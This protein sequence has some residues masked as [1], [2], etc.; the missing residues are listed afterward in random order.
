MTYIGADGSQ[1]KE[2]LEQQRKKAAEEAKAKEAESLE[3]SSGS[4]KPETAPESTNESRTQAAA[5]REQNTSGSGQNQ[6]TLL[7]QTVRGYTPEAEPQTQATALLTHLKKQTSE[8][9]T[10]D[11]YSDYNEGSSSESTQRANPALQ[12]VQTQQN[13]RRESTQAQQAVRQLSN[14]QKQKIIDLSEA[15]IRLGKS[16]E[17]TQ[18]LKDLFLQPQNAQEIL[19]GLEETKNQADIDQATKAIDQ[20]LIQAKQVSEGSDGSAKVATEK[21]ETSERL[22]REIREIQEAEN[23]LSQDFN[24]RGKTKDQRDTYFNSQNAARATLAKYEH[25]RSDTKTLEE[26]KQGNLDQSEEA[27][28]EWTEKSVR[29]NQA[30]KDSTRTFK[31]AEKLFDAGDY[32]GATKVATGESYTKDEVVSLERTDTPL[33]TEL[34]GEA[35]T[36]KD[37]IEFHDE[38][39]RKALQAQETLTTLIAEQKALETKAADSKQTE[40]TRLASLQAAR[41]LEA[42]IQEQTRTTHGLQ[43]LQAHITKLRSEGNFSDIE[44]LASGKTEFK[45]EQRYNDTE[46]TKKAV[47][48]KIEL[49]TKQATEKEYRQHQKES[50]ENERAIAQ[51]KAKLALMQ[52]TLAAKEKEVQ[53]L[54]RRSKITEQ[55]EVDK[56]K[57]EIKKLEAK[58]SGQQNRSLQLAQKTILANQT[59]EAANRLE[60]KGDFAAAEKILNGEQLETTDSLSMAMELPGVSVEEAKKLSPEEVRSKEYQEILATSI[61]DLEEQSSSYNQQ[62]ESTQRLLGNENLTAEQRQEILAQQKTIQDNLAKVQELTENTLKTQTSVNELYSQGKFQEIIA[63]Q[64]QGLSEEQRAEMEYRYSLSPEE[65]TALNYREVLTSS[66]AKFQEQNTQLQQQL[67]LSLKLL[68]NNNLSSEQRQELLNRQAFLEQ[69]LSESQRVTN[70][71]MQ[72]QNQITDLYNQ[73]KYQEII[74]IQS[75]KSKV[76]I[77]VSNNP[78]LI[79]ESKKTNNQELRLTT[80][81]ASFEYQ[82]LLGLATKAD[83]DMKRLSSILERNGR[84]SQAEADEYGDLSIFGRHLRNSLIKDASNELEQAGVV[85]NA[86]TALSTKRAEAEKLFREGDIEGARKVLKEGLMDS[87]G[88]KNE[89][90]AAMNEHYNSTRGEAEKAIN[91]TYQSLRNTGVAAVATVATV[92]SMG[93]LSTLTGPIILKGFVVG[94]AVGTAFG[95]T[96]TYIDSTIDPTKTQGQ[97]LSDVVNGLGGDAYNSAKASISTIISIGVLQG[98]APASASTANNVSNQLFSRLSQSSQQALAYTSSGMAGSVPGLV[99]ETATKIAEREKLTSQLREQGKS[100]A[101]IEQALKENRLDSLTMLQDASVSLAAAGASSFVGGKS[102]GLQNQNTSLTDALKIK[103]FSCEVI[104]MPVS[105]SFSYLKLA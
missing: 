65:R 88:E 48:R 22:A 28:Q 8:D 33:E 54:N 2:Q 7:T 38:V 46:Q 15:L 61:K 72:T 79:Q 55:T 47:E 44:D 86:K 57:A 78:D 34:T 3:A 53:K 104:E 70:E 64:N 93:S 45:T 11:V 39:T 27:E 85:L 43:E 21:Q 49:S 59:L 40:E 31:E 20:A 32:E 60:A 73:G 102:A 96:V 18:A 67:E 66:A 97:A 50:Q 10:N 1:T 71:F 91:A 87:L 98:L 75:G 83:E 5:K 14:E 90:Y 76:D 16:E 52:K 37:A 17:V 41:D 6:E 80:R 84:E 89:A 26:Q 23:T 69:T 13:Y 62:L 58:L 92:A 30:A 35:K 100:P 42:S 77:S 81:E 95:A 51:T 24:L 36:Q 29:E 63:I 19:S 103:E 12:L 105:S 74:D 4:T 56:I 101:E 68:E 25:L 94:T 82:R 99:E 9:T